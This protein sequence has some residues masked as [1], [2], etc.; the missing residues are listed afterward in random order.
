MVLDTYI[1]KE[2]MHILVSII[3]PLFMMPLNAIEEVFSTNKDTGVNITIINQETI[4]FDFNIEYK[5]RRH[6][7]HVRTE[8]S[9]NSLR[10]MND[11]KK[12]LTYDV[13]GSNLVMLPLVDFQE[14]SYI[15]EF[16]F[17]KDPTV[18]LAKIDIPK[19][20]KPSDL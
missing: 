20:L 15:A 5:E 2:S 4:P 13:R 14:G 12:H 10:L 6:Q 7:I 9:L 8:M 18:V 16:K 17:Q 3:L 19:I 1:Q 11:E